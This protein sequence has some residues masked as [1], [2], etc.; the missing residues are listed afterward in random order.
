MCF[1]PFRDLIT[2]DGIMNLLNVRTDFVK[3][4]GFRDLVKSGGFADNGANAFIQSGARLLD[5]LQPNPACVRSHVTD[6]E[7]NDYQVTFSD[8]RVIDSV[9]VIDEDGERDNQLIRKTIGKLRKLYPGPFT[10]I[11]TGMPKY[12]AP[13]IGVEPS[14]QTAVAGDYSADFLDLLFGKAY[15]TTGIIVMPP[16]D[17]VYTIE[18]HGR[19]FTKKLEADTDVSWWSINR[20]E[21]L[22]LAAMCMREMF[23]RNTEGVRG[24]LDP[25]FGSLALMLRGIDRDMAAQEASNSGRRIVG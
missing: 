9:W 16:V 21:L 14:M 23:F 17:Q 1:P 3:K 25:Q 2:G 13:L 8:C 18:V 20:P 4:S 10:D 22:V 7:I 24:Y 12:Y 19:W 15:A 6:L 5:T 11:D